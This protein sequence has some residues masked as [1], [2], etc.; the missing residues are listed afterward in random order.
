MAHPIGTF[1]AETAQK[2][3]E[4][5]CELHSNPVFV[6]KK[7]VCY[8]CKRN[9]FVPRFYKQEA[10]TLIKKAGTAEDFDTATGVS[11]E[12]AGSRLITGCP[13]CSHSFCD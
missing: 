9:I 3:Q 5:Y 1:D 2:A 13:H 12:E 11:I 6:P 7:G 8:S 10:G 4:N